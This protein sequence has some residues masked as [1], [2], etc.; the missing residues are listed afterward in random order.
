M[1]NPT[2]KEEKKHLAKIIA[3]LEE[4]LTRI[5][6]NL[7]KYSKELKENKTY[8]YENKAGMDHGVVIT[9]THMAEGLEFDWVIVPHATQVN[10]KNNTEKSLFY[11]AGT[12]AM[13][14]LFIIHTCKATDYI[15]PSQR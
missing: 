2:E 4:A 12:M 10:Y 6:A 8:L 9:N 5:D 1:T 15:L 3:I 7:T 13:H 11:I 14:R